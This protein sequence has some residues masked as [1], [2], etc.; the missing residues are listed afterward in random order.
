[1]VNR[2]FI[3]NRFKL[4][5]HRLVARE[6]RRDQSLLEDAKEIVRQWSSEPSPAAFVS[7]WA[8]LLSNPVED[9]C[10]EM[11]KRD[12]HMTWLRISSPFLN[13]IPQYLSNDDR[14]RLWKIVKRGY[15][16]D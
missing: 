1:M 5:C 6:L 16:T 8:N 10:R 12:E 14:L 7:D 9:L 3:N 2:E 15:T 11:V 13:L 4:A